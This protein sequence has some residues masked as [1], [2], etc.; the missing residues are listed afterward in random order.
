MQLRHLICP[1]LYTIEQMALKDEEKKVYGGA[2]PETKMTAAFV[3][4]LIAL[5][6]FGV[7]W[8]Y[9]M[10]KAFSCPTNAL[11][12]GVLIFFFPILAIPFLIKGCD[13]P[14]A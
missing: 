6:A 7:V 13:K 3:T 2:T 14:A 5:L 10:V 1:W 8:L 11:V 12:W 9:A 4:I